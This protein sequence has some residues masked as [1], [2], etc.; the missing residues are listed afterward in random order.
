MDT[1][2]KNKFKSAVEPLE[3]HKKK[4]ADWR[5][6][7]QIKMKVDAPP[8]KQTEIGWSDR[9]IAGPIYSGIRRGVKAGAHLV[10]WTLVN[11]AGLLVAGKDLPTALVAGIATAAGTSV[12]TLAGSKAKKEK[13]KVAGKETHEW[14]DSLLFLVVKILQ[15]AFYKVTGRRSLK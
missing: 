6:E 8:E 7:I 15:W 14:T 4:V 12:L 9:F 11:T 13:A 2:F 5:D 10:G 1:N 3:T